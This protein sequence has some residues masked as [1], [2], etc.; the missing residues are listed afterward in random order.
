MSIK[1][2]SAVGGAGRPKDEGGAKI[3]RQDLWDELS[4]RADE[5]PFTA[6]E[7]AQSMALPEAAVAKSLL[8]LAYERLLEK[9]EGS[10]YR[11]TMLK[12]ITQAEFNRALGAKVDPKRQ[13][14]NVEIDRLKK[15][16][17]EMRRRLLEAV[18]DRDRYLAL[19][20]K[21][22][23]DPDEG[24]TSEGQSADTKASEDRA[25]EGQ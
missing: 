20:K 5:E 13:Q 19:L 24:R 21:H 23:I 4:K 10:K 12:S 18:A 25:D 15:N 8:N 1:R 14:G 3:D 6:A 11:A 9:I 7:V 22:S 2:A 16:N 17:D